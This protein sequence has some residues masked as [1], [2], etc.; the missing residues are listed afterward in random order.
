M[1]LN[2]GIIKKDGKIINHRS[3][4]KVAINPILRM[5]GWQIANRLDTGII[6]GLPV[7]LRC[8][9]IKLIWSWNYDIT[10]CEIERKRLLI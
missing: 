5:F 10:D 9:K 2:L 7:L 4:V 1:Q 8:P 3:L 6:V